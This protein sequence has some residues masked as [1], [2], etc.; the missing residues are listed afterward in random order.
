MTELHKAG[1]TNGQKRFI[2]YMLQSLN[3]GNTYKSASTRVIQYVQAYSFVQKSYLNLVKKKE[4]KKEQ[5]Q[6]S[7]NPFDSKA[8]ALEPKKA[9]QL[10]A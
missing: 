10:N 3:V 8:V 5:N 1:M 6:E 4:K 7:L 2:L 9:K